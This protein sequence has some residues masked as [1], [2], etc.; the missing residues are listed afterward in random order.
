MKF[1]SIFIE[2]HCAIT[3]F[4]DHFLEALEEQGNSSTRGLFINSC[5]VHCQTEIQ[6]IWFAPGSPALGDKVNA[7]LHL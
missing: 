7:L 4:R 3:G 6:E 2:T 1:L 5:F